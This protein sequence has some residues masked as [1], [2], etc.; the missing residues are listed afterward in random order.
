MGH[1]P[2][3]ALHALSGDLCRIAFFALDA[4]MVTVPNHAS[5]SDEIDPQIT[6]LKISSAR[7][8]S[9]LGAGRA[10]PSRGDGACGRA[11]PVARGLR[12]LGCA[13][14]ATCL[15]FVSSGS[16]PLRPGLET[17]D[18]SHC[19]LRECRRRCLTGDLR[20]KT[21]AVS[22]SGTKVVTIGLLPRNQALCRRLHGCLDEAWH[23]ER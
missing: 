7:P 14:C 6:T 17:A 19:G 23:L 21:P 2:P 1:P 8:G 15:L 10:G 20:S 11:A 4:T 16:R 22:D 5:R 12:S 9:E 18:R 13:P 3:A